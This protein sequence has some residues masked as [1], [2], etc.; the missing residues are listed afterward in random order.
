MQTLRPAAYREHYREYNELNIY[1]QPLQPCG[2]SSMTHGSWDDEF[3]CSEDGGGVHQICVH[4][5]SSSLPK[6]S[7]STGQGDWSDHRAGANHCV[8]LG[9]WSLYSAINGG[10]ET[11]AHPTKDALKCDA[12]PKKALSERYVGRFS[13]GWSKWNGIEIPDQVRDGVENL[14]RI[15]DTDDYK[16]VALNRNYC[17]FAQTIP[18]LRDSHFY[19]KKCSHTI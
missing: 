10:D 3:R 17:R 15:C 8:C 9:A 11:R 18:S 14:V 2:S 5:I 6:F 12:I 1:D 4:N 16:A 19:K 7:S 13:N